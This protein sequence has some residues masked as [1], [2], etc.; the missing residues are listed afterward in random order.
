M[1]EMTDRELLG[2]ILKSSI[3]KNGMAALE[4]Q[5]RCLKPLGDLPAPVSQALGTGTDKNKLG[6][7]PNISHFEISR[8]GRFGCHALSNETSA[9]PGSRISQ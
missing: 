1:S 8:V 2:V 6:I 4:F 5:D 3:E 9:R 7:G